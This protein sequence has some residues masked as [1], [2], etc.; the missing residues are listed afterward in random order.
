MAMSRSR[1][2]HEGRYSLEGQH[3]IRGQDREGSRRLRRR[4]QGNALEL[5]GAFVWGEETP[6]VAG[7]SFVGPSAARGKPKLAK[8]FDNLQCR[9]YR[10]TVAPGLLYPFGEVFHGA[11]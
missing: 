6:G 4:T 9:N 11:L 3:A 5:A 10:V 8:L 2:V 7:Q 1:R